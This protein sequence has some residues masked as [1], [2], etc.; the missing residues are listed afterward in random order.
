MKVKELIEELS[1]MD[2]DINVYIQGYEDGLEDLEE[3][4]VVGVLRDLNDTKM[5]WWTGPHEYDS[6]GKLSVV[7]SRSNKSNDV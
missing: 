2:P 3:I 6:G 5:F 1:N 7:F 4:K